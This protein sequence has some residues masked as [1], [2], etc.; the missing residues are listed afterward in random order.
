MIGK[1]IFKANFLRGIGKGA[2]FVS[3]DWVKEAIQRE[4]GF[5]PFPGTLNLKVK[6][7][8]FEKLKKIAQKGHVLIPPDPSF[9]TAR[10]IKGRVGFVEGI[11]VFPEEKVWA[12]TNVLEFIAPYKVE[13]AL[14]LKEG[15]EVECNAFFRFIPEG[16]IFD[17]DGTLIDPLEAYEEILQIISQNFKIPP[18]SRETITKLI[19]TKKDPWVFIFPDLNEEEL[20]KAKNLDKQLFPQIYLE[21]TKLLPYA[22]EVIKELKAKGIKLA[23]CSNQL[24]LKNEIHELLD[25]NGLCEYFDL[26]ITRKWGEN[27]DKNIKIKKCCDKLGIEPLF[28]VYVTD[29][30]EEIKIS[31]EIGIQCIIASN[32]KQVL[33]LILE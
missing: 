2:F 12:H 30:V 26:I 8:D 33:N 32:L 3:L 10:L 1:I 19:K 17:L 6:E 24:E 14:G 13:E 11:F 22:I 18:P 7:E 23:I 31:D 28:S 16:V 21:K 9:C 15:T 27:F 20:E 25:K 4:F 29:D 5:V